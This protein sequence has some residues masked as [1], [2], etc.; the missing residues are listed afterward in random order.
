ML[1]L[2][3]TLKKLFCWP[4]VLFSIRGEEVWSKSGYDNLKNLPRS[5]ERH[6]KS[7]EHISCTCK[8]HILGKQNI[9]TVIDSARQ[10]EIQK[11]NDSV[12]KNREILKRLIDICIFLCN[13]ELAFRGHDESRESIN[14]GNFKELVSLMCK[15]DE[16]L[17]EFI[18][19]NS[20]FS[21][22]S[23]TIQNELIDCISYILRQNIDSEINN[24][25]F[26]LRGR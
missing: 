19:S 8:L 2:G 16:I 25:L 14:K 10:I 24:S 21:G 4:C 11:F 9:A 18:D 20:V 13:Q 26:F 3:I 1:I 17:K 12:R 15:R 7:Q 6:S 23:K 22:T 5:I